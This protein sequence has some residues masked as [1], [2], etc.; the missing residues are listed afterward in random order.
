VAG[1]RSDPKDDHERFADLLA[2]ADSASM[3]LGVLLV[4]VLVM[5]WWLR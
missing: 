4:I 5:A 2:W 3:L 1:L